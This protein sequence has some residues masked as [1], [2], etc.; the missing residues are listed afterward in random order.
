MLFTENRCYIAQTDRKNGI[1]IFEGFSG[2]QLECGSQAMH[3]RPILN[4]RA[5]RITELYIETDTSRVLFLFEEIF[6]TGSFC[7]CIRVKG[8][9]PM[10]SPIH[11]HCSLNFTVANEKC[12]CLCMPTERRR[13]IFALFM[14]NAFILFDTNTFT[15]TQDHGKKQ[16]DKQAGKQAGTLAT[17]V[18][19]MATATVTVSY[20]KQIPWWTIT[21]CM[22]FG[23]VHNIKMRAFRIKCVVRI[24]RSISVYRAICAAAQAAVT[25]EYTA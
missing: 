2:D 24:F 8:K 15:H 11:S 22:L 3:N 20:C 19:A 1:W 17:A 23:T 13:K 16:L 5:H 10:H 21:R 14:I 12:L 7:S 25:S 18:I 9:G 4:N 6:S